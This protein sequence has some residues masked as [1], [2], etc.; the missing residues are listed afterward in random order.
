MIT[1]GQQVFFKPEWQDKG[2]DRF[3][4]IAQCDESKG[5]V[6]VKPVNTGLPIPPWHT[7]SVDM[8]ERVVDYTRFVWNIGAI[9]EEYPDMPEQTE[10][11]V[12]WDRQERKPVVTLHRGYCQAFC[13]ESTKIPNSSPF[14][15]TEWFF[16]HLS[17]KSLAS[18]GLKETIL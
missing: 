2:D 17:N 16:N 8:I 6:E 15:E 10:D 9:K 4:F 3:I 5:R 12:L 11:V 7:V 18:E 13:L 1:K 14:T